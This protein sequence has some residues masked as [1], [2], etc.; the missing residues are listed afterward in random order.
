MNK[1]ELLQEWAIRIRC[2]FCWD[3]IRSTDEQI[4]NIKHN[5]SWA[6]EEKLTEL[7]NYARCQ[8]YYVNKI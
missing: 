5:F 7:V 4:R 3:G 1:N 8:N 6:N 2:H